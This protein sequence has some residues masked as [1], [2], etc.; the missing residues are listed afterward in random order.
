MELTGSPTLFIY[1][2]NLQFPV[3]KKIGLKANHNAPANANAAAATA[4]A[5]NHSYSSPSKKHS[6][7][8]QDPCYFTLFPCCLLSGVRTQ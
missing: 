1:F 3:I 7:Y 8:R 5:N 4:N 6:N 2:A